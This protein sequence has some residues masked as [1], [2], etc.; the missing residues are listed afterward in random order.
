MNGNEMR[1]WSSG[2]SQLRC[3]ELRET[4]AD[5]GWMQKWMSHV[6]QWVQPA[7]GGCRNGCHMWSSGGRQLRCEERGIAAEPGWMQKWMSHVEQWV[8]PAQGGCRNGWHMWSSGCR[9]L[10]CEE[11]GIAADPGR[12]WYFFGGGE[13]GSLFR[14]LIT[15]SN[16]AIISTLLVV[17][18]F[19]V[20]LSNYKYYF[21]ILVINKLCIS[22][23]YRMACSTSPV[24]HFLS[25]SRVDTILVIT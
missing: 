17:H 25:M 2:C 19:V 14:A 15:Y 4:A 20:L 8:Q 12:C 16:Q 5:P 1:M 21:E 22:F 11:R 10:R 6:E 7:Q 18:N 23:H 24:I 9:Q 13:M 3:E